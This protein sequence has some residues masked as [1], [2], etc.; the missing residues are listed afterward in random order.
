MA[1]TRHPM[2]HEPET[3]VDHGGS[4]HRSRRTATSDASAATPSAPRG[5]ILGGANGHANEIS[6]TDRLSCSHDQLCRSSILLSRHEPLIV[7]VIRAP[8]A[9]WTLRPPGSPLFLLVRI[10]RREDVTVGPQLKAGAG[11]VVGSIAL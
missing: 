9:G 1:S 6:N 10:E 3:R 8:G 11:D 2:S 4:P 5:Q 7:S